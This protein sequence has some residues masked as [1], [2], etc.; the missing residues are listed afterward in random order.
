[1]SVHPWIESLERDVQRQSS[2][3]A[4]SISEEWFCSKRFPS[5][6]STYTIL[7]GGGGLFR[8]SE[9]LV[10]GIYNFIAFGRVEERYL[11]IGI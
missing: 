1:M 9:N 7:E 5:R 3:L 4:R 2:T 6:G 10:G 11:C 8:I